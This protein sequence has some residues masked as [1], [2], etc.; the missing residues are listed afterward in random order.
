M[1][2]RNIRIRNFRT[3]RSGPDLEIGKGLA[4]VGPNSSGKTNILRA[5]QMLFTGSEN[6]YRYSREHDLTFGEQK[7]FTTLTATFEPNGAKHDD[8]LF[9]AYDELKQLYGISSSAGEKRI[10]LYVQFN[11]SSSEPKYILFPNQKKPGSTATQKIYKKEPDFIER[12]LN[13]FAVYYVPS[14]KSFT[15]LYQDIV[16]PLLRAQVGAILSPQIKALED[17]LDEIANSLSESLWKA[18]LPDVQIKIELPNKSIES[19][20]GSFDFMLLDPQET[21]V[22]R[23]GMGIQSAALFSTFPWVAEK[24]SEAGKNSIWLIEEP[25]SFLHPALNGTCLSLLN[26]LKKQSQVIYTTHSLGFVP[27]DPKLVIGTSLDEE[28]DTIITS[29]KTYPDATQTLRH[30]L[31]IAFSDFFNMGKFNVMV[32]GKSDR[33][34]FKWVLQRI[35]P[36]VFG[37]VDTRWPY[38][39]NAETAFLDMGGVKSVS[40]FLRAVYE[41]ASKERPIVVVFDGDPAGARER[42]EIQHILKNKHIPFE[43]NKQYV[44]VRKDFSIEGLFPDE[45]V[46]NLHVE[47]KN[48]FDHTYSEDGSDT[49]ESFR[50]VDA[51]K[52]QYFN[53]MTGL[54]EKTEGVEWARRWIEVCSKINNALE[55]QSKKI[56]GEKVLDTPLP[57]D[58]IEESSRGGFKWFKLKECEP[59][60]LAVLTKANSP[61]TTIEVTQEIIVA[62]GYASDSATLESIRRTVFGTLKR[63]AAKNIVV[64]TKTPGSG[65]SSSWQLAK[66]DLAEDLES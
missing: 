24:N 53:Y 65:R 60:S 23:K 30:S 58:E 44:S 5:I 2:L 34:Y 20:L 57:I 48:W 61:M 19:L 14:E 1:D 22:F 54:A 4:I 55:M 46:K 29:F 13:S 9:K 27:Q 37:D 21:S 28:Q 35:S 32:E 31:G 62:N 38:L 16:L 39:R 33:E 47:H 7:S 26:Q 40:G 8:D 15:E 43:P 42:G 6:R 49:L 51:H 12:L 10:Q 25:E 64:A 56:Y 66:T 36:V 17:A 18:D 41:I 3:V 50:I 63:L 11:K 45:W 59:L 52:D